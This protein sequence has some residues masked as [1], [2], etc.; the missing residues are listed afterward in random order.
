MA[1]IEKANKPFC[2]PIPNYI[3]KYNPMLAKPTHLFYFV[4]KKNNVVEEKYTYTY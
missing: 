1:K 4:V 3:L 2:T